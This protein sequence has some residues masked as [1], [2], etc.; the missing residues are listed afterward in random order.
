MARGKKHTLTFPVTTVIASPS[1]YAALFDDGL[2]SE[3]ESESESE[4]QSQE[5]VSESREEGAGGSG[6]GR[7]AHT[8][9]KGASHL[10]QGVTSIEPA[11]LAALSPVPVDAGEGGSGGAAP[12]RPSGVCLAE[13]VGL[14]ASGSVHPDSPSM[15]LSDSPERERDTEREGAPAAD[16]V[17]I[18]HTPQPEPPAPVSHGHVSPSVPMSVSERGSEEG[19][20]E[21]PKARVASAARYRMS[22]P[23]VSDPLASIHL[24]MASLQQDLDSKLSDSTMSDHHPLPDRRETTRGYTNAG[25]RDAVYMGD[26]GRVS[27]PAPESLSTVSKPASLVMERVAPYPTTRGPLTSAEQEREREREHSVQIVTE[28]ERE[29]AVRVHALEQRVE[30]LSHMLEESER[31]RE[32]EREREEEV[33][34][35][36]SGERL[37]EWQRAVLPLVLRHMQGSLDQTVAERVA[38]ALAAE[39]ERVRLD[40]EREQ[41]A[42]E[43]R[44]RST[45]LLEQEERERERDSRVRRERD[46]H[47]GSRTTSGHNEGDARVYGA[48][49]GEKRGPRNHASE[50][51]SDMSSS[52]HPRRSGG[53]R[54]RDSASHSAPRRVQY[55]S[56][57]RVHPQS[58][59]PVRQSRPVSQAAPTR[60]RSFDSVAYDTVDHG[61]EGD[62]SHPHLERERDR[63]GMRDE[64]IVAT[65]S[66][67]EDIRQEVGRIKRHRRKK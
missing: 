58:V 55:S 24:S 52:R 22:S 62:Y 44:E 57:G 48:H 63:D 64:E 53:P 33:V 29:V 40:R 28:R 12:Q 8:G 6:T 32:R 38:E 20:Q 35:R 39:R 25:D 10:S 31:R 41:E 16:M 60:R 26:V 30:T 67:L 17:P 65:L 37:L 19:R 21:R 23:V 34:H 13:G 61:V 54:G 45:L 43:A 46:M 9:G 15:E 11:S 36:V 4:T 66:R 51:G 59:R 14:G 2:A 47:V 18:G 49:E 5:S 56:D 27:A 7:N 42:R 1:N 50:T 3:T